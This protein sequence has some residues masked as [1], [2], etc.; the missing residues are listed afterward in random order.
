MTT[1]NGGAVHSTE[2]HD[3]V[4]CTRLASR[5][6][7][8]RRV[9]LGLAGRQSSLTLSGEPRSPLL[10]AGSAHAGPALLATKPELT[11]WEREQTSTQAEWLG[12]I[13]WD[14][15][16]SGVPDDVKGATSAEAFA[17]NVATF[18]NREDGTKPS[19]GWPWPWE[20]SGTTDYAYAFDDGRVWASCFGSAW[21]DPFNE[22]DD[23]ED[24]DVTFPRF[25]NREQAVAIGKR[26]GLIVFR[27]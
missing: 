6:I 15:Y 14:G 16:P 22:P 11:T 21:F 19:D 7:H 2:T 10:R 18:I 5:G 3:E 17:E 13:A 24:G 27:A 9:R 4:R 20:D 23:H 1:P 8:C 12:S 25:G 26:S